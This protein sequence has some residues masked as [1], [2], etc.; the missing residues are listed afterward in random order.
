MLV[1]NH[2]SFINTMSKM[3]VVFHTLRKKQKLRIMTVEHIMYVP[4]SL[5]EG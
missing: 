3:L 1:F 4:V 5:N 2:D